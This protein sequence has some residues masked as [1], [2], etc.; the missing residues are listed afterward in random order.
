M[1]TYRHKILLEKIKSKVSPEDIQNAKMVMLFLGMF[2]VISFFAIRIVDTVN[3]GLASQARVEN[4]AGQVEKLERENRLLKNDRDAAISESE[5]EAQ[6]R[7]LGYKKPGEEV[8]IINRISTPA[9][10]QEP[11]ITQET[12]EIRQVNWEL[13]IKAIFN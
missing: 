5:V 1:V 12:E 11:Q 3:S 10:I 6:Y 9:P 13:W 7:A 2:I 8:Y 4:V